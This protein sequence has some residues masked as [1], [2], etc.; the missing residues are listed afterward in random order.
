MT[1]YRTAHAA[2]Q[3]WSEVTRACIA[4]LGEAPAPADGSMR[5]GFLYVTDHLATNM[6]EIVDHL[7]LMTGIRDWVG[8]VGIGILGHA[9]MGSNT[10]GGSNTP[11]AEYFDEPAMALMV[12]EFPAES[13]RLFEQGGGSFERQHGDW[14]AAHHPALALVHGDPRNQHLP[15]LLESLSAAAGSFLVGGLSSSRSS[16]PQVAQSVGDGS[17]SGVMFAEGIA[18][19]TGLSQGC[20]PIGPHHTIT[21]CDQNIV[22]AI[23]GRPA[24]DVFKEEI[25]EVLSRNLNRVAGFIF[26]ALPLAG[27]DAGD[28]LVRGVTGIDP[29]RGWIAIGDLV[30]T[31]R[32]IM[33]TRRDRDSAEADLGRMVDRLKQRIDRPIKGGIYVSCVARGINL[34]GPQAAETKFILDRL[35][36]IPLIGFFANGEI[37]RQQL[38]GHTGVLT[39]FY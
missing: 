10:R 34:F 2:G 5:L 1:A 16:F 20:S 39:L 37:S 32:Q 18:V 9:P 13:L 21:E 30:E 24:L 26:A 14:I 27:S 38:Y 35:G 15:A 19:A 25:G 4:Q 12:G 28:Y 3:H 8:T 33:F 11:A 36:P 31:G 29:K 17:T 22:M 7:R 23:D 6:A